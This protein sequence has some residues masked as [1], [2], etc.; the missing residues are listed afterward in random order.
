MAG[1][2]QQ[3]P[4]CSEKAPEEGGL[5][6]Y[7]RAPHPEHLL[8]I[9]IASHDGG[10]IIGWVAT[11]YTERSFDLIKAVSE[12]IAASTLAEC[13]VTDFYEAFRKQD[14]YAI[15]SPAFYF[16][17]F[18]LIQRPDV[19]HLSFEEQLE[20]TVWDATVANLE[21]SYYATAPSRQS[22]WAPQISKRFS[23]MLKWSREDPVSR[24]GRPQC[25]HK[26]IGYMGCHK[27]PEI[28]FVRM[29]YLGKSIKNK[30]DLLENIK[31]KYIRFEFCDPY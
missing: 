14:I 18:C 26:V 10:P 2:L 3:T 21:A 9:A 7:E 1:A 29:E 27:C 16:V 11:L 23:R 15:L 25:T 19:K 4:D 31:A 13:D 12:K 20:S 8:K 17:A 28:G 30:Q 22:I 24:W 6:G 5:L